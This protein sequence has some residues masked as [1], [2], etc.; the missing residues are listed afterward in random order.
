MRYINALVIAAAWAHLAL[1]PT[2]SAGPIIGTTMSLAA[3]VTGGPLC[4]I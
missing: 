4:L 2:A 3:G 1:A